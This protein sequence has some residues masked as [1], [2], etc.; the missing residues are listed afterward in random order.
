MRLN[1][2]TTLSVAKLLRYISSN[3]SSFDVRQIVISWLAACFSISM[4]FCTTSAG[5]R[6]SASFMR[7]CISTADRSGSAEM[8]NVTVAENEPELELFDSM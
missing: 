4:P 6:D 2:S 8:S 1:R 7:F 3:F 5:R